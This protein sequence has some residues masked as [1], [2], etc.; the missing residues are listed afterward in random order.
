LTTPM[1][2]VGD[3]VSCVDGDLGLV[4]DAKSDDEYMVRVIWKSGDVFWDPW[5]SQ[6]FV[7]GT[8]MFNLVI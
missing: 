8:G 4:L 2:R 5:C 6:D 1:P 7:D 3:L